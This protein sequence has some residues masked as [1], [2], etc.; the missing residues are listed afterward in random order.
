MFCHFRFTSSR[1]F[2]LSG[3]H[4]EEIRGPKSRVQRTSCTPKTC[5]SSS[6]SLYIKSHWQ[7]TIV[8]LWFGH[9]SKYFNSFWFI[10]CFST[11]D[12]LQSVALFPLQGLR[13]SAGSCAPTP[14]TRFLL[15]GFHS[16]LQARSTSLWGCWSWTEA[17][18]TTCWRLP[19]RGR[20]RWIQKAFVVICL[21]HLT[22]ASELVS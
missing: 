6:R 11:T 10:D 17:S 7:C 2:Q 13:W 22:V 4:R 19:T 5:Q 14:P 8:Y 12:S 3:D 1:V 16:P 20:L 18:T 21:P 9:I 15:L